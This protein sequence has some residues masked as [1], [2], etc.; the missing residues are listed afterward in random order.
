MCNVGTSNLKRR[1]YCKEIHTITTI[2]SIKI[3]C[4][5]TTL[6]FISQND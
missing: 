1:K 6:A 3:L 4:L 5:L 2:N